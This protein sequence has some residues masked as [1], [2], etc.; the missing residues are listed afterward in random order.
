MPAAGL[1]QNTPPGWS[2]SLNSSSAECVLLDEHRASRDR[3]ASPERSGHKA[4]IVSWM[5]ASH[6]DRSSSGRHSCW[7]LLL[8]QCCPAMVTA[9]RER[10]PGGAPVSAAGGPT[11]STG[12]PARDSAAATSGGQ[13]QAALGPPAAAAGAQ[14]QRQAHW[15]QSSAAAEVVAGAT[16]CVSYQGPAPASASSATPRRHALAHGCGVQG[17]GLGCATHE[18]CQ[19]VTACLTA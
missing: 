5:A 2:A 8:T 12:L 9:A 1:H 4:T 3:K 11:P 15:D 19:G 10:S 17:T 16:L 6:S 13:T 18:A 7:W 14:R